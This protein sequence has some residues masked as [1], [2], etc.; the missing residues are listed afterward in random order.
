MSLMGR[1]LRLM[2]LNIGRI[3]RYKGD[4]PF[5]PNEKGGPTDEM[6]SKRR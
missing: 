4:G 5:L 1:I 2:E 3:A 6:E